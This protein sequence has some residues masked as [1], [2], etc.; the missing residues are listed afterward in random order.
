MEGRLDLEAQGGGSHGHS[1]VLQGRLRVLTPPS[2]T[3]AGK[4]SLCSRRPYWVSLH[5]A[6]ASSVFSPRFKE[7]QA[8]ICGKEGPQRKEEKPA[9]AWASFLLFIMMMDGVSVL[10]LSTRSLVC[11]V[12]GGKQGR[13]LHPAV[14]WGVLDCGPW[15][16]S[17]PRPMHWPANVF[18][19]Q[20][21]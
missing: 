17:R 15:R 13:W 8:G 9:D 11:S 4:W 2:L 7:L 1:S 6:A 18:C 14:V 10:W 21:D 5:K 16:C 3:Q 12:G 19:R 20:P